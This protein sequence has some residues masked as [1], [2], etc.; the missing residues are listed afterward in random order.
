MMPDTI[1]RRCRHVVTE[2]QRVLDAANALQTQD[3]DRFGQLMYQSHASLRD[4][5]EVSCAEL[6]LL[7]DIASSIRGVDGA[8]MMGGGFGGCTV[9]LVQS[10]WVTAFHTDMRKLYAGKVGTVP[11]LYI[12]E[13]AQGAE[14][15]PV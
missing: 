4:D 2:D 13:P 14:A 7:V 15:W 9:N 5:Y 6:D 11:D 3:L 10:D 12:C 1:Y 8:R